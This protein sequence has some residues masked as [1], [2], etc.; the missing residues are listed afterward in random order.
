MAYKPNLADKIMRILIYSHAYPNPVEKTRSAFVQ[1]IVRQLSYEM[2]VIV[3]APVPFLL[4]LQRHKPKIKVPYHRQESYEDRKI[5]VYH[6]R[7]LLLPKALL[8]PV[9]AQLQALLTYRCVQR[10]HRAY[11]LDLVQIN[12]GFPDGIAGSLIC[13]RLK[14]PYVITEHQGSIASLLVKAYYRKLLVTAYN[15]ASALIAVSTSLKQTLEKATGIRKDALVIPNGIDLTLMH[16]REKRPTLSR[17][18]YVGYLIQAK[19]I[20]YLLRALKICLANGLDLSLDIIGN[21]DYQ[22]VLQN[23]AVELGIQDRVCFLGLY[24]ADQVRSSLPNYDLLVLPS[25]IE[26]FGLVLI[27]AMASGLPVLSTFSG[28]P[29]TIVTELTGLLVQPGSAQTLAQ[30]LSELSDRWLSFE[31]AIIREECRKM[32]AIE[33]TCE[34]IEEVMRS[35]VGKHE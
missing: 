27:E 5:E 12:W 34:S 22:P 24:S 26:S 32:F 14:L 33:K 9:V 31:P 28:G 15:H 7:Y 16:L 8:N 13:K 10:L 25:L 19:G 21:G 1:E 23:L 20:Q 6:P 18:V 3:V 4:N 17:L 2:E 35:V 11:K 29:E 30:G